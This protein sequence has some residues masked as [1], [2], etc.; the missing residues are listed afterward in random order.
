MH[1]RK[2]ENIINPLNIIIMLQLSA[3][4]EQ[5][6]EYILES[7]TDNISEYVP[8]MEMYATSDNMMFFFSEE[9]IQDLKNILSKI[10]HQ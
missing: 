2:E 5:T 1:Y 3:S 4:E 8:D 9:E 10:Q 6:L 7:V